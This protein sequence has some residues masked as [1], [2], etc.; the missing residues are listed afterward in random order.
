MSP[1]QSRRAVV[2]GG[3]VDVMEEEGSVISSGAARVAV[4]G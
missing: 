1:W 2:A 4:G 3:V